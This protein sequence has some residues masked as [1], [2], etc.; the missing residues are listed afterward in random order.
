MFRINAIIALL[1]AFVAVAGVSFQAG[2]TSPDAVLENNAV[3]AT[4]LVQLAATK[5]DPNAPVSRPKLVCQDSC[6]N[7]RVRSCHL[8]HHGA[9]HCLCRNTHRPC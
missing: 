8:T 5:L 9:R 4:P 3:A 7:H 1:A 6:V 2:A